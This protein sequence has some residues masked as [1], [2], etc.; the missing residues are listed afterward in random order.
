[1]ACTP[2]AENLFKI[3]LCSDKN[4][5]SKVLDA[6]PLYL[7]IYFLNHEIVRFHYTFLNEFPLD[8]NPLL[9]FTQFRTVTP[10]V[11]WLEDSSRISFKTQSLD[12]YLNKLALEIA[13]YDKEGEL[14]HKDL[15]EAGFFTN[16]FADGR[17][18]IRSYKSF[19]PDSIPLIYGLGDKTGELNRWGR[20]FINKPVDALGYDSTNSDPLYKDIPF[21][22]ALDRFSNKAHGIFFDNFSEK[23]FDFGKERK[24]SAYYYFGAVAG[25]LNYYYIHGPELSKVSQ[26]F[27]Q[28]SGMPPLEPE[29]IFGYLGSGMAYTEKDKSAERILDFVDRHKAHGL[30]PSAFHLSSGYTLNEKSERMQFIWNREKFPDPKAFVKQL[31]DRDVELCVNLKP[32]L[33]KSHPYYEEAAQLGL[34]IESENGTALIIDYWS[35]EGAYLDFTKE[36]TIE[37]WKK[38][39]QENLLNTGLR[40]IWNDNNEYEIFTAHQQMHRTMIMPNL[41]SKVSREALLEMNPNLRPWIISRSGYAGLQ[42][43]AGTWTGDNF[44]SFTALKYDVTLISSMALSGLIHCGCDIGG[45]WGDKPSPE[46]FLRWIQIGVFSPRFTIHSYKE[47]AT[48]ILDLLREEPLGGGLN[49]FSIAQ[50]YLKLREKLRA[51]IYQANYAAYRSAIPIQR[52]LVYDFQSDLNTQER[53]FE[54]MF[55][56]SILVTPISEVYENGAEKEVYL[57]LL[58]DSLPWINF[59]NYKEFPSAKLHSLSINLK[60]IPVFVKANSVVP[61]IE[62]NNLCFR[63]FLASKNTT[64]NLG[65]S[66]AHSYT[67]DYLFYEDDGSSN[68]YL[69]NYYLLREFVFEVELLDDEPQVKVRVKSEK[70]LWKSRYIISVECVYNGKL[71]TVG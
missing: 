54:Y 62:G 45:F 27:I 4:S 22:I 33:L 44:S 32:V 23:F 21:F 56:E 50:D 16:L 28:L 60:E 71:Y 58:E 11:E 6:Q 55:G 34:F 1:M 30:S 70:G 20:R 52:P 13:I 14:I 3:S 35:G 36:K 67:L 10:K 2:L 31:K 63:L 40:G 46:L 57:P 47:N 25:D 7:F 19:N 48:E 24:P 68:S 29:F 26:R 66:R 61:F 64:D 8:I 59:F 38:K 41:M 51:Y 12:V 9:D 43:Y 69:D 37:W 17:T 42:K 18:E 49:Y 65:K 53:S 15:S 39:I 5:I